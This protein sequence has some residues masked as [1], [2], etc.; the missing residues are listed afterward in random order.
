[1]R[2]SPLDEVLKSCSIRSS[3]GGRPVCIFDIDSTLLNSRLRT[4]R[5]LRHFVSVQ[6]HRFP[7]LPE[8]VTQVQEEELGYTIFEPLEGHGILTP[9]LRRELKRHWGARFFTSRWS[10]ED[11]PIRGAVDYV[12]ACYESGASILYLTARDTPQMDAG[13]REALNREGFPWPEG[14]RV[15]LMMKPTGAG[16]DENFKAQAIRELQARGIEVFASFENEPGNANL[17]LAGFPEAQHFLLETVHSP[18]APDP[19][20]ALHKI[21]DFGPEQWG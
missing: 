14:E 17:F 21:P 11:T 18:G 4:F 13:T 2:N 20:P 3:E 9:L 15:E 10:S 19:D 6:G 7:G 12:R 8:R 16:Q 1:M 5:I